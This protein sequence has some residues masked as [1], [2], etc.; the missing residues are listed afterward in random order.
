M[1]RRPSPRLRHHTRTC[2][3][4][5]RGDGEHPRSPAER[6]R[7][8][9]EAACA[10]HVPAV[11]LGAGDG[12]GRVERWERAQRVR[13]ENKGGGW[14]TDLAGA[15]DPLIETVPPICPHEGLFQEGTSTTRISGASLL[16]S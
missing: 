6:P 8:E 15:R 7:G 10:V 13:L 14:C 11:E 9:A 1:T 5:A 3:C 2:T 16:C 4:I 12:V